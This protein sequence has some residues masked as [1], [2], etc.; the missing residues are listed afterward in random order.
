MIIA[1]YKDNTHLFNRLTAWWTKGE[2]S[3]AEIIFRSGESGSASF[4]DKGVRLKTIDYS[5]NPSRWD[6]L[7]PPSQLCLDEPVVYE[8]IKRLQAHGTGYSVK[9]L[10]GFVWQALSEDTKRDFCSEV[11][12]RALGTT[13]AWRCHPNLIAPT[14]MRERWRLVGGNDAAYKNGLPMFA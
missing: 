6:F 1:L 14:L 11:C 8:Y 5:K 13:E 9:G 3:H 10:A 2:Y 4:R 7:V 12:M